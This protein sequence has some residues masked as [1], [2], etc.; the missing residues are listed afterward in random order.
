MSSHLLQYL[1]NTMP[2]TH[3]CS[4]VATTHLNLYLLQNFPCDGYLTDE[5][6]VV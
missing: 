3:V 4:V 2:A 5:A 1:L 6:V